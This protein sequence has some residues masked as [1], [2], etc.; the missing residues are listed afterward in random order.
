MRG[1]AD[2]HSLQF[3]RVGAGML[4]RATQGRTSIGQEAAESAGKA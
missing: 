3:L 4:C 1:K 2:V